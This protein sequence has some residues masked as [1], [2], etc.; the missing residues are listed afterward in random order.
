MALFCIAHL[1]D[2]L[3]SRSSAFLSNYFT[4]SEKWSDS[5]FDGGRMISFS[6]IRK[7]TMAMAVTN[8]LYSDPGYMPVR[9]LT[10]LLSINAFSISICCF[11]FNRIEIPRSGAI[12]LDVYTYIQ[13][14]LGTAK[15]IRNEF[16]SDE[17]S[18]ST[19]PVCTV[20]QLRNC[21]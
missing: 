18:L 11:A 4:G 5:V 6:A 13:K 3:A 7:S 9:S 16:S 12:E 14:I 2:R 19:M 1:N 8:A 17:S 15:R 21:G 20:P 10:I